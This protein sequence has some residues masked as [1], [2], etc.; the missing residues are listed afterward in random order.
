MRLVFVP[1]FAALAL[2]TNYAMFGI[3][4]VKLM[5]ALVFISAFLFGIDI[6]LGTA[7]LIWGIY[8]YVNPL[9][10]DPFPLILFL[11]AG[12]CLYAI[13]G[14]LIRKTALASELLRD[15]R[16]YAKSSILFGFAGLITTFGYDLLT[17]FA[18][19]LPFTNSPYEALITGMI[20]GAPLGLIH[21]TSN[22]I[23]FGIAAPGVI[24]A[25]KDLIK[26]GI[27]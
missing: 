1:A 20:T 23:F 27:R 10:P 26:H 17:N 19:Y 16:K 8:G 2:A 13:A 4:N 25:S 6:G 18:T 15:G 22:V 7:V 21:E 12:E 9:G 3:T 11:M 5:D 24:I 14:A